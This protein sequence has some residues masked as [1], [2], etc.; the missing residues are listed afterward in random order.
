MEQ[1]EGGQGDGPS[2]PALGHT[3]SSY[4]ALCVLYRCRS[5]REGRSAEH[6]DF[7][8]G[9]GLAGAPG[10]NDVYS[11]AQLQPQKIGEK[12]R[13]H[14]LSI[15]SSEPFVFP[16]SSKGQCTQTC[17]HS[18]THKQSHV[19]TAPYVP[20]VW[21]RN[22]QFI[23][24]I[25][26]SHKH[27][28]RKHKWF[29]RAS[30]GVHTQIKTH[31]ILWGLEQV[32]DAVLR[33]VCIIFRPH[34]NHPRCVMFLIPTFQIR[35]P[36]LLWSFTCVHVSL[37]FCPPTFLLYVWMCIWDIHTFTYKLTCNHI[38]THKQSH[39]SIVRISCIF[40]PGLFHILRGT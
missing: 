7:P 30:P 6:C 20:S 9:S 15:W 24:A 33:A 36:N 4:C 35:D 10:V 12:K 40:L 38:C 5:P 29:H 31:S 25:I 26:I 17:A 27:K 28:H 1:R 23:P 21:H 14:C 11:I 13:R 16:F 37:F 34:G 32:T 18:R 22:T 19:H 2:C 3:E 39:T 8:R